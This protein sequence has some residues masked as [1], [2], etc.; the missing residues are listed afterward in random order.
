[1]LWRFFYAIRPF[2]HEWLLEIRSDLRVNQIEEIKYISGEIS[3]LCLY[4][5]SPSNPGIQLFP[6]IQKVFRELW[7]DSVLLSKHQQPGSRWMDPSILR[8]IASR[9]NLHK[10]L[11]IR[12]FV[13]CTIRSSCRV[14][15]TIQSY[16]IRIEIRYFFIFQHLHI[17]TYL[18]LIPEHRFDFF[19]SAMIIS[20]RSTLKCAAEHVSVD[21][22]RFGFPVCHGYLY[23][24]NNVFPNFIC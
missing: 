19:R 6:I 17:R 22:D 5:V 3:R 18:R 13:P 9:A 23:H 24:Q 14:P 2:R 11:I 12:E 10:K 15:K 20:F 8:F 4:T 21:I 7:G 1:M 16:A